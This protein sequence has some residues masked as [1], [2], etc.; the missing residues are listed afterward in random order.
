MARKAHNMNAG[1]LKKI[2]ADV[3]D[4][5]PVL[6]TSA[7]FELGHNTVLAQHTNLGPYLPSEQEFRD[8]FD[9]DQYTHVVYHMDEKGTPCLQIFA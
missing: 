4:N 1:E 2:L 3:P 8:A 9:G 6:V 5:T 7:N